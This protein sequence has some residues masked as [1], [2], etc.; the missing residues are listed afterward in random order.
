[1]GIEAEAAVEAA[2]LKAEAARI[3][4]ESE[5]ERLKAARD[6]EIEFLM[7]QNKLEVEKAEKMANIESDKF[8]AMVQAMGQDTLRSLA[9]GPQD[10]QVR[11][12]QALGL[13][14]TLITDGRSPVNLF[15]TA[16][17]LL[18]PMVPKNDD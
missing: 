10:H 1:M 4:A 8:K 12:L 9:S 7:E 16:Q 5:L 3:E 18:G 17:G 2:K 15:S 11:M 13:Q 14:S 6:A